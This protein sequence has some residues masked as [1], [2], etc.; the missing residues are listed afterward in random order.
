MIYIAAQRLGSTLRLPLANLSD[1]D[2]PVGHYRIDGINKIVLNPFKSDTVFVPIDRDMDRENATLRE[3]AKLYFA[4]VASNGCDLCPYSED[5]DI[6][7]TETNQMRDGCRLY[8][9]MRELGVEV[10]E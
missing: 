4:A 3:Y 1:M 5:Y 7:D 2:K 9:E 8:E 6:C 10:E